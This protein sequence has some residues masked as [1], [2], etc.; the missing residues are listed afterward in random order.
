MD[1]L[2]PFQ[3]K[4]CP[5]LFG[6]NNALKL[7]CLHWIREC[8][9]N[10]AI[11]RHKPLL[12]ACPLTPKELVCTLNNTQ[13]VVMSG[14][15]AEAD[16]LSLT[17]SMNVGMIVEWILPG[18]RT[19][20]VAMAKKL[21]EVFTLNAKVKLDN[22]AV[23]FI[24][25]DIWRTI[26]HLRKDLWQQFANTECSM[27]FTPAFSP[28]IYGWQNALMLNCLQWV[29][30]VGTRRN[31]N[32]FYSQHKILYSPWRNVLFT[33]STGT[34]FEA[35]WLSYFYYRKISWTS[36]RFF[37]GEKALETEMKAVFSIED[38]MDLTAVYNVFD[39][40]IT[41]LR[42]SLYTTPRFT[43]FMSAKHQRLGNGS[44]VGA[45]SEDVCRMILEFS[46]TAA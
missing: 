32:D 42:L 25:Q 17:F 13:F 6:P 29:S 10:H 1:S 15:A 14:T 22:N 27:P 24:L 46:I 8:K 19:E 26:D 20:R 3:T 28:V 45:L 16:R 39:R 9:S 5:V 43:A 31:L 33:R 36:N 4:F 38:S 40:G 34:E 44:Q 23:N 18:E 7:N 37:N 41:F 12:R 2:P 11:Q 30:E 35:D 21:R